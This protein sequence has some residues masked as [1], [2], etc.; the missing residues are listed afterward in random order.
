AR[1]EAQAAS[2]WVSASGESAR[3]LALPDE[4]SVRF[5]DWSVPLRAAPADTALGDADPNRGV[6]RVDLIGVVGDDRPALGFLKFLEP[7]AARAG[8]GDTPL[9]Y[10]FEASGH[11]A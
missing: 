1:S 10:L 11:D 9:R 3:P 5:V 2:R 8:T 4:S 6:E 7:S